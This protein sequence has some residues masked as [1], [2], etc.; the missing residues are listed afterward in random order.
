[1]PARAILTCDVASMPQSAAQTFSASARLPGNAES[2][3]AAWPLRS[4][5]MRATEGTMTRSPAA[6]PRIVG[7][8]QE[9]AIAVHE[10]R[11]VPLV[12]SAAPIVTLPGRNTARD[13]KPQRRR[14]SDQIDMSPPA[15]TIAAPTSV[16]R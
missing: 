2:A 14:R 8:K 5:R 16:V 12:V 11:G 15:T 4:E 7:L 10:L 9:T 3:C 6:W 13:M 1:M